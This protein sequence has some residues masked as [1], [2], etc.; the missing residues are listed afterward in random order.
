MLFIPIEILLVEDDS[1]DVQLTKLALE[2]SKMSVNLHVVEDGVE[3][4]A[5]LRKEGKYANTKHPDIILLDLNLPKK[6]GREVLAEIKADPN[7]KRIPVIVLTASQA[8]TD[9]LNA[10]NLNANCYIIKPVDF[11]RFVKIVQSI[12]NFWFTIVRLP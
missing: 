8:E 6:D 4:L 2:E 12:E 7:L 1:G 9:I 10:Y 5:L 3:A 11:D